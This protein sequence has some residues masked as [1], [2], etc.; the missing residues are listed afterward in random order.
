MKKLLV[1]LGIMIIPIILFGVYHKVSSYQPN[2]MSVNIHYANGS[3]FVPLAEVG[4]II[5]DVSDPHDPQLLNTT[6]IEGNCR[7]IIA[8]NDKAYVLVN[9]SCVLIYDI[10]E[11]SQPQFASQYLS[12]NYIESIATY[13]N[14]LYLAMGSSGVLALNT[15]NPYNPIENHITEISGDVIS[16]SPKRDEAYAVC[17]NGMIYAIDESNPL[18]PILQ[19]TYSLNQRVQQITCT[20]SYVY[21]LSNGDTHFINGYKIMD[22]NSLLLQDT[23]TMQDS[24]GSFTCFGDMVY[25]TTRES[26]L[27]CSHWSDSDSLKVDGF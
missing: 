11:P 17:R 6:F 22:D 26:I 24:I 23:I 25:Y 20:D 14:L 7:Q 16:V 19:F 15:T 4:F 1:I 2:N 27:Y 21:T 12:T 8:G 3:V 10:T 13:G 5:L 18:Y 9:S